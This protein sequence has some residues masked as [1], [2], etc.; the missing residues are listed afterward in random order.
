G[1]RVDLG[2]A[3]PVPLA[4]QDVVPDLHV[5]QD[6]GDAQA[7]GADDPRGRE[8][9][10]EEDDAAGELQRAAG[11]DPPADVARVGLAAGVDDG[12]AD[13]VELDG[14]RLEVVVGQVGDRVD[15]SDA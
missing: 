7:G 3:H 10:G 2:V 15:L 8:D 9:A 13:R 5:L 1:G 6:L 14:D 11:L 4:V 12:L